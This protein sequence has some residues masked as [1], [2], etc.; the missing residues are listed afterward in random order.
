[1]TKEKNCPMTPDAYV[2]IK[3]STI[4][5]IE[6]VLAK[7]KKFYL[8][9]NFPFCI[10]KN[11]YRTHQGWVLANYL[12]THGYVRVRVSEV[13]EELFYG[14]HVYLKSTNTIII[15]KEVFDT[16]SV[17]KRKREAFAKKPDVK[18][19]QIVKSSVIFDD[20]SELIEKYVER[21][22]NLKRNYALMCDYHSQE[23]ID[24][25]ARMSDISEFIRDLRK[26]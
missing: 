13:T 21:L 18:S 10:S 19:N 9:I 7:D 25:E 11:G 1:M 2:T 17:V 12:K 5:M 22:T 16:Y 20:K 4:E 15:K 6:R 14:S 24:L 26:L 23:A 8:N 3:T